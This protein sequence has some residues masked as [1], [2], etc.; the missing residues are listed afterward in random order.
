MMT[1]M[2]KQNPPL[3]GKR[4]AGPRKLRCVLVE[5]QV[6]FEQ[7]LAMMLEARGVFEVAGSAHTVDQGIK[8]C[9]A[10]RPDLLILD[11]ALPD[12]NGLEVARSLLKACPDS[13]IIVV[14]ANAATFQ[15]PPDLRQAIYSVLDKTTGVDLLLAEIMKF[16]QHARSQD[17]T[18]QAALDPVTLLSER[19]LEVFRLIGEGLGTKEI[20]ERLG[21]AFLTVETHR[22]NLSAKLGTNRIDLARTRSETRLVV[23]D[24]GPGL[25]ETEAHRLL[26]KSTKPGGS[27]MGLF[28]VAT[29]MENHGGRLE[30]ARSPLGGAEFRMVFPKSAE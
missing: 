12:G 17:P 7:M 10:T 6:M 16:H 18:I 22:R 5:D 15:C 25:S 4:K 30:I 26:L 27:G 2:P 23:G 9:E 1:T 28:L 11:L 21:R 13:R 8:I 24:S 3:N 20:A 29:A 14:S 19:E